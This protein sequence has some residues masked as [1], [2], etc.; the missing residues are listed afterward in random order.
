MKLFKKLAAVA[1]AAV[2][3]LSMVGCGNVNSTKQA[4]LDIMHDYA[5]MY[6]DDYEYTNTS[7]MD[8]LAQKLLTEADN[9]YTKGA[10]VE[11]LLKSTKV[12]KAAGVDTTKAYVVSFAENYEFKSSQVPEATK[13][14]WLMMELG[15][16]SFV[17]GKTAQNVKKAD[18]GIAIGKIGGTEYVVVVETPSAT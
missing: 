8:N 4:L 7:E 15:Q 11:S 9:A 17:M 12:Q 2:L 13:Q 3:A 6:G 5:A 16:N 1:L 10:T 18:I 14:E